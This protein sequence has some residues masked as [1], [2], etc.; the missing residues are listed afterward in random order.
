MKTQTGQKDSSLKAILEK[1]RHLIL[2]GHLDQLGDLND[3]KNAAIEALR[4]GQA[5]ID[6]KEGHEIR[7]LA[8]S[9]RR[10]LESAKRGVMSIRKRLDELHRLAHGTQTYG[11]NGKRQ[12]LTAAP[13]QQDK[14]F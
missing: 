12:T 5:M 7:N 3:Q 4:S 13:P 6:A 11:A 2:D 9:N 10:L 1:E 8:L 14:S